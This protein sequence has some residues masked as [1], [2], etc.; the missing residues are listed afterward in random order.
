MI[1]TQHH[2]CRWLCVP[3]LIAG[4]LSSCTTEEETNYHIRAMKTTVHTESVTDTGFQFKVY[5]GPIY[6]DQEYARMTAR[7]RKKAG[8]VSPV[9]ELPSNKGNDGY[10]LNGRFYPIWKGI[11]AYSEEGYASWYGPGFHGRKT[12]NGEIYDQYAI[13]AAHKSLPIPCYIHVTNLENG[14]TLVVRVNDRGPY[15][16]GRLLDLSYGAAARLGVVENGVV[17]IKIDLIGPDSPLMLTA[18]R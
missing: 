13:S 2:P 3:L 8:L 17:R 15:I 16:D 7:E 10:T 6:T 9:L 5:A 11:K 1:L 4:L 18:K 12:A 14:R